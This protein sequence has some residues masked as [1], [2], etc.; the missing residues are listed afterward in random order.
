MTRNLGKRNLKKIVCQVATWQTI[1]SCCSSEELWFS[2]NC[3]VWHSYLA[4]PE[5]SVQ[6]GPTKDSS[7]RPWCK[8]G[9]NSRMFT[10]L[11]N[12]L[13]ASKYHMYI[14]TTVISTCL[15]IFWLEF[16]TLYGNLAKRSLLRVCCAETRDLGNKRTPFCMRDGL[17]LC[18]C[19]L[20][21]LCL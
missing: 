8:L 9:N 7:C 2:L 6:E 13:R 15:F 16:K 11:P 3:L 5:W 18:C 10:N 17:S 14:S 12:T 20:Q 1:F 4:I 21:D 19:L